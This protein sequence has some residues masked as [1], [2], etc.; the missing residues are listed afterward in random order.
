M[1]RF[2][3]PG[4][5]KSARVNFAVGFTF[6][7][8]GG[9]LARVS[10]FVSLWWQ[11]RNH[12]VHH[13]HTSR[14]SVCGLRQVPTS[15]V[16][17]CCRWQ[18]IQSVLVLKWDMKNKSQ[19]SRYRSSCLLPSNRIVVLIRVK[20]WT[21][22]G[23]DAGSI[24][25]LDILLTFAVTKPHKQRTIDMDENPK[26]LGANVSVI[27]GLL[28]MRVVVWFIPLLI[29]FITRTHLSQASTHRVLVRSR[30]HNTHLPTGSLHAR[31]RQI[32]SIYDQEISRAFSVRCD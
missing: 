10:L 26:V 17:L 3:C 1:D 5:Q 29:L 14:H 24:L 4:M 28:F 19:V 23:N 27:F 20:M 6:Y 18:R 30:T 2:T 8:A 21:V 11:G 9:R 31:I 7:V 13:A 15:L 32:Y 16:L 22:N 25:E 12:N